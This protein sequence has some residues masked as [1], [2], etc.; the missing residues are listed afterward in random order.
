MKVMRSIFE[1]SLMVLSLL[2]VVISALSFQVIFQYQNDLSVEQEKRYDS[3]VLVVLLEEEDPEMALHIGH[4][5][6][7]RACCQE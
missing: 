3:Y 4:S 1:Y 6:L 5:I 7:K 2:L